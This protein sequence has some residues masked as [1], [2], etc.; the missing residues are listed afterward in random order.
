M[1]RLVSVSFLIILLGLVC[2]CAQKKVGERELVQYIND[3]GNGVCHA[4]EKG[5][6]K[7]KLTY[8][9][10]DLI[11]LQNFS[12]RTSITDSSFNV[13]KKHYDDYLYFILSIS[14]NG[15]DYLD[16]SPSLASDLNILAFN[17][18]DYILMVE[19]DR[20]TIPLADFHT[21]RL[22]GISKQTQILLVFNKPSNIRNQIRVHLKSIGEGTTPIDFVIKKSDLDRLPQ[23]DLKSI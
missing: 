4:I 5:D 22:Y 14:R 10:T 8:R 11:A 21:P 6:I 13:A 16:P 15:K 19:G 18:G 12:N 3:P 23:L 1:L 17:L 20:D 9:P 7:Y 2:S